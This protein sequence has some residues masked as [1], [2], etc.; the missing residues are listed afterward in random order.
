VDEL[1][2]WL[3]AA[4][5]P[6]PALLG[7]KASRLATMTRAGFPVPPGFCVTTR[8]DQQAAPLL[9]EAIRKACRRLGAEAV[10]VRSS[11]TTEDLTAASFAGQQDTFLDVRGEEAVL[12]AV[13][14]CR[15]SLWSDRAVAYR[16]ARAPE[17]A[18]PQMA[19]VVQSL[20]P[21]DVAGVAF[22]LDPLTGAKKTVVESCAGQGQLSPDQ[23]TRLTEAVAAL[24][25]L[26]GGPQ[27][28]EWGFCS[29]RL[30]LFQS[31][32]ITAAA[33]GFFT[34]NLPDDDHLWTSGFLNER[35]PR[36]VS[37]LGWTLI[38]EL[39]E[40]LAFLDPLRFM[41]YRKPP[42]L[43]VT[44]LHGG[45]PYVN[46]HLFQVL[47]KP[48]PA[49]LLPED[50]RRYFPGGDTD[51]RHKA[52]YPCRLIDPRFVA[53]LLWH[54]LRDPANWS[55]FHNYRVWEKFTV[56][57]ELAMA[58]LRME[59]DSLA[60]AWSSMEQAQ[61]LN[62]RLL[63]IHRWSLTHA[64][65][66]Y[67]LL[68][69]MLAAWLGRERANDLAPRL[70]AGLPNRSVE[71]NL[72]LHAVRTE[73]DWRAFVEVY[74]HR[75]FSLDVCRPTFAEMPDEVR[76]SAG[77]I[78]HAEPRSTAGEVATSEARRQLSGALKRYLFD[79][80]LRYAR[81]YMILREDQRFYW[82]KTLAVQRRLALW[83]GQQLG[84]KED[85][86]FATFD[87]LRSAAA[88]GPLP[89]REMARRRAEFQRLERAGAAGYPSFLQGNQALVEPHEAGDV[90]RGQPVSP[91]IA[92]GP[93]RVVTS[94]DQLYGLRPGDILVTRG[95]DPA[96][97]VV[98]GRMAG[99]VMECGGQL[100][101]G[102]VVAREYGLPAVAG[103]RGA[104][105]VLKNGQSILVDG[106]A[107]VL[108]V[109]QG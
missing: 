106:T 57:H 102:A 3:D 64:D 7:G 79:F 6:G 105:Q 19:V 96:W 88:G 72:A 63:A 76:R 10:A 21:A 17:A 46:V 50:A 42:G 78:E 71:L 20:I 53:S 92:R 84:Q 23:T 52:A 62:A 73:A 51:L 37:P 95:A 9:E 29:D 82:Q 12:D 101:H 39:L 11:A 60:A 15:A 91:G 85:I 89:E 90:L 48:F 5:E 28:V 65:L 107:G 40:P 14:R 25:D 59:L 56:Q 22:S 83:M 100:S 18:E 4:E 13:R 35:F 55:P 31:R 93:A 70:V 1:I 74:G 109:L 61:A 69:R 68:R 2:V 54:F 24:E 99:L 43:P 34:E 44:K 97:T 32:P 98:F 104:T 86:F 36:P 30:W 81:R 67:S 94:P 87:E 45:H 49:P 26:F 103:V 47:Y 8:A 77:R 27:D 58:R 66:F 108:H 38:K 16:Q 80:V 41:G 33:T 75:S